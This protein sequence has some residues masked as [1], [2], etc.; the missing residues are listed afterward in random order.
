MHYK[1]T[2]NSNSQHGWW[3]SESTWSSA[4]VSQMYMWK[5]EW[6]S[7]DEHFQ[8]F[9]VEQESVSG[10]FAGVCSYRPGDAVKCW[11]PRQEGRR[12]SQHEVLKEEGGGE[13]EEGVVCVRMS[14][15]IGKVAHRQLGTT[16]LLKP[17]YLDC[18]IASLLGRVWRGRNRGYDTCLKS[19]CG[20]VRAQNSI[21]V[22]M[23]NEHQKPETCWELLSA[24]A[25]PYTV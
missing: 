16:N 19:H 3:L 8:P 21:T 25:L 6:G 18:V 14:L 2:N 1:M 13:W 9:L 22:R 23:E 4:A 10:R 7:V 12:G 17:T 24:A 20:L 5:S 15:A 11:L